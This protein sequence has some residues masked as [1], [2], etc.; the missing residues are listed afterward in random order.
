MTTTTDQSAAYY[1]DPRNTFLTRCQVQKRYGWGR[2]KTYQTTAHSSFPKP[3]G[4]DRYRLDSLL[5]WEDGQ[6]T[7]DIAVLPARRAAITP[8]AVLIP[9]ARKGGPRKKGQAA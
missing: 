8:V 7:G 2:T 3:I 5:R 9:A 1:D 6:L 4:G